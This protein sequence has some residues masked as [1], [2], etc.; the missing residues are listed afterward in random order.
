MPF[1]EEA[2]EAVCIGPGPARESYLDGTRIVEAA[3]NVRADAVHPGYGFLSEDPDFAETVEGAGLVFVGPRPA[4]TRLMGDK[5]KAKE[6]AERAGVPVNRGTGTLRTAAE[7]AA[8]AA[9]VGYPVLLKAAAGGGGRGMRV[10]DSPADLEAEFRTASAEAKA[11]FGRSEVFL[12][13][14]LRPVRHV[15]VQVFG[16]GKGG[17]AALG[18]RECSLQRRHQKVVEECPSPAVDPPLRARLC[19]AAS[20]LASAAAYRGAGTVEFLLDGS[21]DFR[22]LEVNCRLQVEH[23]VTEAALGIDLVAAQLRLALEGEMPPFPSPEPR[24]SALECRVCAE[25][26]ANGF[27]PSTGRIL[28]LRV[29]R[30]PWVRWDGGYG[31]GD[32]VT[33]HYDSLLGKL[34]CWGATREEAIARM[35]RALDGLAV[36]GPR[37]NVEFLRA[38]VAHPRFAEGRLSTSFLEEEFPPGW[39]PEPCCAGPEA[40]LAAAAAV[41]LDRGGGAGGGA[42]EPSPW[43]SLQGWRQGR[44]EGR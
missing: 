3:R 4:T 40:A 41:I 32:A 21:G 16:D 25:D 39:R 28:A 24:G 5:V 18:E 14:F 2:D 22:F 8:E 35:V 1:A 36:L 29:P 31:T 26:P 11:A 17:V 44:E 19:A 30:E 10:V 34:V 23:P 27:L 38:V 15:E 12:E 7:A 20:A 13:R 43:T 6:A 37:T 33:P 42:R 9:R